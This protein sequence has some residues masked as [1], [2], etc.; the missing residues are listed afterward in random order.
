M[1]AGR[2]GFWMNRD[3]NRTFSPERRKAL[4]HGIL[5]LGAVSFAGA[6]VAML[7]EVRARQEPETVHLPADLAEGLSIEGPVIVFR[8]A[9]G[10]LLAYSSRCTHLGC[11]L[12]RIQGGEAV[13]PCHG[14]RFHPDGSVAQGPASH[15]LLP[16]KLE[17]DG[18]SGGWI[19]RV[20]S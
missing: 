13:C 15:P 5:F 12:D 9:S 11:R 1:D 4:R 14:S 19:A 10:Q 2:G 6:L 3:T 7:R 18:S 20:Q 17:P 16:V 8:E